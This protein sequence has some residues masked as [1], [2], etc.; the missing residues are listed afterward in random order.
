[1]LKATVTAT[2]YAVTGLTASTAYTFSVKAKDA[3]GNSS[4]SSN[5]VTVTTTAVATA[6]YCTSKGNSVADEYIS[7]VVFGTINNTSTGGNGYSDFT[8][9]S[10]SVTKGS[11]YTITITPTWTGTVYAEGYAVWIDYNADGDFSDTGELVWSKTAST[12]TPVTG[13]VTIPATAATGATRMRV[14]LK[15]N[16]VP[17][18]CEAFSYGEVEDYTLNITSAG[19]GTETIA[20]NPAARITLFPNPAETQ[21][22]ITNISAAAAYRIYSITGQVVGSGRAVSNAVDVSGLAS[23]SYLIEI[24][25]NGTVSNLKFLKK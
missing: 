16:G 24:N 13:S 1:V 18:A 5:T 11:A 9:I 22:N 2:T 20:A 25:D 8:S 23:G 7:K 12:T 14:S 6:T 17:T 21:L 19:R 4:A 3:A 10:A 15:Y